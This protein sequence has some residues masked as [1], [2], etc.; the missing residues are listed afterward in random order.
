[1]MDSLETNVTT[2]P[3]Q[4]SEITELN[5]AP[6]A[7]AE[8]TGT[9]E[10]VETAETTETVETTEPAAPVYTT[11]EEVVNRVKEIAQ[12]GEAGDKQEVDLL[13][14]LFYKFHNA[15]I[16]EA[17]QAFIDGGGEPEKFGPHTAAG[18]YSR[19]G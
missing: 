10:A 5:A 19:G 2:A 16:T 6:E 14:Q 4:S 18:S 3:E 8:T 1:M 7:T 9:A 15:E 13:K 11:K 17:R 12:S